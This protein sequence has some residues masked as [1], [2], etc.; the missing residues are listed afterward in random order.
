MLIQVLLKPGI[1]QDILRSIECR[2]VQVKRSQLEPLDYNVLKMRSHRRTSEITLLND[3]A[4][5][6]I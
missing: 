4:G 5:V 6:C 1:K 2:K 3:Q